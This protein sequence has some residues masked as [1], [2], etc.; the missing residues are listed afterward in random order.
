[1]EARASA[2]TAGPWFVE[3]VDD[4][5]ASSMQLVTS[6]RIPRQTNAYPRWGRDWEGEVVVAATLVQSPVPYVVHDDQLS[7]PDAIFISSA[8]SD[9][10]RLV[11][12]VRRLRDLLND[13]EVG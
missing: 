12:E 4:Y 5:S 6:E 3:T 9:V 13:T 8:R 2:A 10:P 1:M 7:Y 11:A